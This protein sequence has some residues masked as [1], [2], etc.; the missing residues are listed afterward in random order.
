MIRLLEKYLDGFNKAQSF[1]KVSGKPGET[2]TWIEG[3]PLKELRKPKNII[4]I[5]EQ[6]KIRSDHFRKKRGN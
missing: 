6:Y 1:E 5:R 2:F 4:K 3:L